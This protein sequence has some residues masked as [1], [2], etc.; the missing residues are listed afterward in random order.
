[1]K[2]IWDRI[3]IAF[4]AACVVHCLVVAF[5]PLIF[6]ALSLYNHAP[7]VHVLVGFVILFT[8]P[9]AFVPGYRKHGITWI[10]SLA[11]TGF[12]F[13]ALGYLLEDQVT[14]QLSHGVSILGSLMLVFAHGKN[15]QH[16]HRHQHLCC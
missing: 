5:I 7:W 14:D 10:V 2:K 8:T 4:S 3:G 16:S 1:M 12:L 9:L 13:I 15:L 6:P 11:L